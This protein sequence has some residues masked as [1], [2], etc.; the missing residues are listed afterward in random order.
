[1]PVAAVAPAVASPP[2]VCD[3]YAGTKV[4]DPY[5]WLEDQ[6]DPAVVA[7]T[8]RHDDET[9]RRF[10]NDPFALALQARAREIDAAS[11]EKLL[12]RAALPGPVS[13][14]REA[15]FG[16]PPEGRTFG[17]LELSP[18]RKAA[19]VTRR[20]PGLDRHEL[21]VR[22]LAPNAPQA[23]LLVG[24]DGAEVVWDP[25]R[26]GLYYTY[27]PPDAVHAT[28]FGMRE[29]RFHAIGSA[30]ST[31][32]IL[33][34]ASRD[35]N[36]GDGNQALELLAQRWLLVQQR[37]AQDL[38]PTFGIVDVESNVLGPITAADGEIVDVAADSASFVLAVR[39][40]DGTH[41]LRKLDPTG[42]R[43]PRTLR[44]LPANARFIGLRRTGD[45]FLLTFGD[46]HSAR[47]EVT[48]TSMK[49]L[50][51][52]TERVGD[53]VWIYDNHR[54]G[55]DLYVGGLQTQHELVAL[56]P[57]RDRRTLIERKTPRWDPSQLVVEPREAKS[58]DGTSVPFEV[59]RRRDVALDGRAPLWV[60][61][62]GG[63]SYPQWLPFHALVIAWVEAGGIYAVSH[64]RGGTELG[65]EWRRAA[66]RT[67]H[68]RTIED[69]GAT[70]RELHAHGYGSPPTTLL[71][72]RSHGGLTAAR[73]GI[74]W[75]TLVSVVLAEVP[76]ADMIRFTERGRGGVSEYGDP[77]NAQDLPALLQISS[78]QAVQKSVRYPAFFVTSAERDERVDPM[79]PDKLVAALET[80]VRPEVVLRVDRVGGHLGG[81][82][83]S[84]NATAE[85]LAWLKA[86]LPAR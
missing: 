81:G 48:D 65:N 68:Y 78:V 74:A 46:G 72:G 77:A 79:H 83:D 62:Y 24:L 50:S 47:Y 37:A 53:S 30:Q 57:K 13:P 21:L 5:R 69:I 38:G 7:W 4:C 80:S 32:R 86:R 49:T 39:H 34:P 25:K 28:R 8:H 60:Y 27:T 84:G 20:W 41:S 64:A 12:E 85:A 82:G 40:P 9:R 61:A 75:P 76:L 56:D 43:A 35:P 18:D 67:T 73:T 26:A 55:L 19:Y 44:T 66:V 14:T 54:H 70:V 63:F 3:E 1:M 71:H 42:A 33:V 22:A 58:P 45:F 52:W 23:D 16:S 11:L 10:A 51:A 36:S 59:I 15:V 29:V 2:V 17:R 31:D 6:T